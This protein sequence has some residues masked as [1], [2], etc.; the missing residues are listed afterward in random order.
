MTITI[1]VAT[2][3]TWLPYAV[4]FVLGFLLG[5]RLGVRASYKR[6]YL[7]GA[8]NERARQREA[9]AAKVTIRPPEV[10]P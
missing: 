5:G 10:S 8:E 7:L 9:D 3:K 6:F 2:V 4:A 1:D